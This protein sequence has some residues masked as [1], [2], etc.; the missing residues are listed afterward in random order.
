MMLDNT[1]HFKIADIAVHLT[2][3]QGDYNV[4]I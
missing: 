2:G 1:T 3:K 4:S